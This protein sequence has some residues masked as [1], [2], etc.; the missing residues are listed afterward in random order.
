MDMKNSF[1]AIVF[2]SAAL[3]T[4]CSDYNKMLKVTDYEYKYEVAKQYYAEGQYNRAALLMQDVIASM[5]G[6]ENGEE[7]L[8]LLGMSSY[9]SK[10][11]DAAASYFRK[12]Y[13]SYPKGLYAEE[14]R[15]NCGRSLYMTT[16]EP[17]LDQTATYEAVTEFQ[18][19]L[20]NYP[21]SRLRGEAQDLIF[22]LQD[23]LVE[24]EYLSAKLYY[25]LGNYFLNCPNG[26][27]N[28]QAC[29]VTAENAVKDFPYTTR[30]EDFAILILRAKFELARQS[31]EAKKEER[32]NAAVDEYYG[33]TSEY[34]E[35]KYTA[36]AN[37]LLAGARKYL[38]RHS[39]TSGETLGAD[40]SSKMGTKQEK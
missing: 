6:T 34:P 13:Q 27:S 19:F 31:V 24:K 28:Y 25:N 29:I 7:S 32:Y 26:G 9:K 12:Y 36:E 35:S 3:I 8:Y 4:S 5:K 37:A 21:T 1:L 20:E 30:R 23:K 22:S 38:D 17:R 14:A 39:G 16:P 33:F 2:L 40:D 18:Q 11:Y 10:N 15:F